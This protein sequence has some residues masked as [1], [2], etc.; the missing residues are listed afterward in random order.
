MS[1]LNGHNSF[2]IAVTGPGTNLVNWTD[3]VKPIC[4]IINGYIGYDFIRTDIDYIGTGSGDRY[5][6]TDIS[7]YNWIYQFWLY[8]FP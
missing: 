6:K 8:R 7:I 1:I 5:S 4:P 2:T 3:I